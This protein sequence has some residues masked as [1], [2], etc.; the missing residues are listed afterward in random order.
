V[1][2]VLG[3]P[4]L[5][6]IGVSKSSLPTDPA[7]M[8]AVAWPQE[9]EWLVFVADARNEWTYAATLMEAATELSNR[10]PTG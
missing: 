5:K 10:P 6:K 3:L 4:L 7:E 8:L 2:Q 9:N 1:T